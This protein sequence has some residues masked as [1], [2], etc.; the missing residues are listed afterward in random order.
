MKA[1]AMQGDTLDLLCWRTLG[2][3][4]IVEATLVLNPGLADHGPV[5]PTGLLVELANPVD[6]PTRATVNLW[7]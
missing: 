6:A 2:R 3:T 1:R 4:D 7:D 5:L